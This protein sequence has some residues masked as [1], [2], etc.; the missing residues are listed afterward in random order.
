MSCVLRLVTSSVAFWHQCSNSSKPAFKYS[1]LLN[2]QHSRLSNKL[3]GK[4]KKNHRRGKYMK[5][6][7]Y[8][9][10]HIS[11]FLPGKNNE[12][13]TKIA[14]K[15]PPCLIYRNVKINHFC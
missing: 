2:E 1:P 11:C 9:Y 13:H 7:I 12:I 10:I 3:L 5:S 8:R 14:T 6:Y 15:L 4:K